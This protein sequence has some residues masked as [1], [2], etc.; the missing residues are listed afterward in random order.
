MHYEKKNKGKK[1][2]ISVACLFYLN[3]NDQESFYENYYLYFSFI[4][5]NQ[6]L[7]DQLLW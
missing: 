4:V 3:N 7:V 5:Q 1:K 2:N 6:F